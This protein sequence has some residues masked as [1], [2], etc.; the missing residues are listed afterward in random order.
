MSLL[1]SKV[2]LRGVGQ[3]LFEQE[4][5]RI[6]LASSG[7]LDRQ[8]LSDSKACWRILQEHWADQR[9]EQARQ[10]D[11]DAEIDELFRSRESY[12][13]DSD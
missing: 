13:P 3:F 12:G 6:C 1:G 9:C 2:V 10:E 7:L 8:Q 5:C 4:V 11:L